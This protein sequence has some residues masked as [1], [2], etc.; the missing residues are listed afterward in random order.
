MKCIVCGHEKCNGFAPWHSICKY[1]GYESADLQPTI[2]I[3]QTHEAIDEAAREKALKTLRLDNFKTII[4]C[5]TR[6][7]QPEAKSLLDVGSAHGWFLEEASKNFTVLGIEPDEIVRHKAAMKGLSVR[8]GYFPEA[9][10]PG[11]SFD[12]IVFNDVIEHIPDINSALV[13]ANMRLND[14]GILILNL[15]CSSGFFYRLSTIFARIGWMSPF[16]RL[17]QKGM[18]S[19]HVHYFHKKNLTT[20]VN[21][22]GFEVLV[23]SELPSLHANGLWERLR[24]FGKSNQLTLVFQYLLILCAIPVLKIFPS[25]ILVCYLRKK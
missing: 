16:E 5:A 14:G 15:P 11:E 18:P 24:Y 12:V 19:P 13:A 6:L 17:W 4:D 25:D 21:K 3:E 1:C 10:L 8:G 23:S 22:Q 7:V 20:L 9:L 2:N